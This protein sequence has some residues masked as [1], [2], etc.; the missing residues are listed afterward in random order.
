MILL[1]SSV[2]FFVSAFI[3][4]IKKHVREISCDGSITVQ[5]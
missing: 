4:I 1:L 5:V 2:F 3:V